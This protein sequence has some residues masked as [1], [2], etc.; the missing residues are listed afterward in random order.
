M[1]KI[2]RFLSSYNWLPFYAVMAIIV[3]PVIEFSYLGKTTPSPVE[4]FFDVN[5]SD[6]VMRFL[7]SYPTIIPVLIVIFLFVILKD[8]LFKESKSDK[9]KS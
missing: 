5:N 3:P 4:T 6:Y 7:Y 2:N 9:L 8:K 1:N